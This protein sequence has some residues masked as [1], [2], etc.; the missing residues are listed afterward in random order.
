MMIKALQRR[1]IFTAMISLLVLL[2]ILIAGITTISY[3]MMEHSANDTL[4]MLSSVPAQP[5][6]PL[7]QR[8]ERL[9]AFGYQIAPDGPNA[10][11]YF[12]VLINAEGQITATDI[13]LPQ[14]VSEEEISVYAE[15]ALAQQN[16]RG[17]IASYKYLST[18]LE[19]GGTQIVFLD[20]SIQAQ[21]LLNVL[22]ISGV[23]ALG[24]M[25]LM[26]IIVLI[27]SKR[28][29]RPIAENIAKQRRF[30]T[31]AG[32]EIKTPLA[33]IMAN[34]DA[35][36]LHLGESKW[37]RN[38]RGQSIRLNGL[39]KNLLTLARFDE[40]I[41]SLPMEETDLSSLFHDC[42][43]AFNEIIERRQLTVIA[44]IAPAI[45]C[46]G[47]RE[48]LIQ[49]LTILLD[50]A[51]KYANTGGDITVSLNAKNN[52]TIWKIQN[53]CETLP[54]VQPSTLFD[55]FYRS[56][57]ARTQKNGGYGIGLSIA[58]AIVA[59]HQ[60]KIEAFYIDPAS[61]CFQVEI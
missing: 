29:I 48:S 49:L 8:D 51:T 3:I 6:V 46:S 20:N 31:D 54:G 36:E 23:V 5:A 28:A 43:A 27:I 14:T 11:N 26:F 35:L 9:P 58:Q 15:A 16:E 12:T 25:A 2:I 39:M 57:A 30:V 10:L 45:K 47:N 38:I 55:R 4:E 13:H 61:I 19:N 33:I 42:L 34:T 53:T 32:H 60:G 52:K 56:D 21:T 1:F 24:C 41:A 44:E 7:D 40:D 50:N 59:M 17:K 22:I 37:S 18:T